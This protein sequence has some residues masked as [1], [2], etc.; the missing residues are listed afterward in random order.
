MCLEERQAA[1]D[2]GFVML[3][4][5]CCSSAGSLS[6]R[7]SHRFHA[8]SRLKLKWNCTK[9]LLTEMDL[10][11]L[12]CAEVIFHLC[13]NAHLSDEECG[14][15]STCVNSPQLMLFTRC[16]RGDPGVT[17]MKVFPSYSCEWQSLT[18]LLIRESTN[19]LSPFF[20]KCNRIFN[21]S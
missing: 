7:G 16:T 1:A 9:Y 3:R 2:W 12:R 6:N 11:W 21:M 15:P 4:S 10:A 8:I 5:G 14:S 17:E 18:L 13:T 19:L 20:I